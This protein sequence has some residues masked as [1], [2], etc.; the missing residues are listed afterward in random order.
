MSCTKYKSECVK[1]EK[2]TPKPSPVKQSK[3]TKDV[4][5]PKVQYQQLFHTQ[6]QN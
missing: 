6:T 2:C 3:K 4:Y 1:G 5:Y